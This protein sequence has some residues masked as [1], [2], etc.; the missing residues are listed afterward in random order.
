VA[1]VGPPN[2]GKSSLLRALSSARPKVAAYPFTTLAPQL[3]I[4]AL[5][6]ARALAVVEV[7]GLIAGAAAGRGLGHAFL[8][9]VERARA[10]VVVL[11]IAAPT[12]A[13]DLETVMAELKQYNASLPGN[14]RVVVANKADLSYDRNAVAALA[15]RAAAFGAVT[16]QVSALTGAGLDALK[17]E[18]GVLASGV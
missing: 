9:H 13:E 8:R 6:A 7:P 4:V 11:D 2:V 16:L 15:E 17:R 3:G 12:V 10:L 1:L 14:V 18:L 5:S